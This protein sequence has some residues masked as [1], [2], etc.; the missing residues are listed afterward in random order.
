M[1]A[2]K[3][4]EIQ[5]V[6]DAGQPV[7]GIIN[8]DE[9]SESHGFLYVPAGGSL[10]IYLPFYKDVSL[11]EPSPLET[12][13]D[14]PHFKRGAQRVVLERAG[15][16]SLKLSKEQF[17]RLWSHDGPEIGVEDSTGKT[18]GHLDYSVRYLE[19]SSEVYINRIPPGRYRI[20]LKRFGPYQPLSLPDI[21]VR[22]LERTHLDNLRLEEGATLLVESAEMMADFKAHN[23]NCVIDGAR[24]VQNDAKEVREAIL[25]SFTKTGLHFQGIPPSSGTLE[26]DM[27]KTYYPFHASVEGLKPQ[28]TRVLRPALERLP[29]I[30]GLLSFAGKK[31]PTGA[32]V[33]LRFTPTE[34]ENA[35]ANVQSARAEDVQAGPD[36]AFQVF[37]KDGEYRMSLMEA[38][39]DSSLL[40][41]IT[42]S[43]NWRIVRPEILKVVRGHNVKGLQVD[44]EGR[45]R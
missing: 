10:W 18:L 44:V 23:I 32:K 20:L 45:A 41:G 15:G 37:L 26:I 34:S 33:W 38:P 40:L 13:A 39:E 19:K 31:E 2:D 6:D 42:P 17:A 24:F 21:E 29:S 14:R 36:G 43:E 22:A 5:V 11:W 3:T 9:V 25:G 7:S 27:L 30:Q 8:Q 1:E 28:E 12:S 4:H 16:I 35:A